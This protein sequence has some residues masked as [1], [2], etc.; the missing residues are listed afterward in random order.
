LAGD[1]AIISNGWSAYE[2]AGKSKIYAYSGDDLIQGGRRDQEIDGGLGE[3]T[4]LYWGRANEYIITDQKTFI[5]VNDKVANR[6]GN[7]TLINVE[8]LQFYDFIIDFTKT[9][10][11]DKTVYLM[12]QA[13]LGRMPDQSGFD[14][15]T[16]QAETKNYSS[17]DLANIFSKTGEFTD[18]FGTNPTNTAYVLKLYDNVLGRAPDPAGLNYW[19][20][21]LDAGTSKEQ[22][23]SSFALGDENLK[24]TAPHVDNGF[25]LQF[26]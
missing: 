18:R 14:Y 5:T 15:W 26:G 9:A 2:A 10:P 22:V 17:L 16:N 24:I 19:V 23:L 25:W 13:A 11:V 3:D 7:D 4:S 6:D 12:Y 1:D 8:K 20:G 21:R